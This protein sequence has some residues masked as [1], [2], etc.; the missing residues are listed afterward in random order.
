MLAVMGES[1]VGAG[2][3]RIE[4][5]VGIEAFHA[6]AA[7]RALV[8][9]LTETLKARP[10]DLVDRVDGLLTR[11]REAEKELAAGRQATLLGAARSIATG[12]SSIRGVRTIAHDAG[13]V[14]S[15]DDVRTLAL[16]VRSRLGESEPVVVA[17][18]GVAGERA[19]VVV[20]TNAAAR[21]GGFAAGPLAKLGALVLGGGG[22]GKPDMAQGGG[23]D[24]TAVPAA[25][26]AIEA[27]ISASGPNR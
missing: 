14:D 9:T 22:G 4:A 27:Q 21:D 16:D 11:L 13:L 19:V 1:S 26:A 18:G 5:L 20:A 23:T 12:G 2:A 6:L 17:V 15:P 7:E 3:R 24:V 25:L 10:E 8:A